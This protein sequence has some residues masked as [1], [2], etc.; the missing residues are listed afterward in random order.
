MPAIFEAA[1]ER[2]AV[3][4]RGDVLERLSDGYWEC[5]RWRAVVK[6]IGGGM[7][8]ALNAAA[9]MD[10]YTLSDRGT[11]LSFNNRRDLAIVLEGD[12]RLLNRYDVIEL[13]PKLHAQAKL[14]LAKQLADWLA[15]PP[16]QKAIGE[17]EMSGQKLFRPEADPKP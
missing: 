8:A 7:G 16:G 9:G 12:S 10:P 6:D 15:S 4:V 1:F 17:Y 13:N 2:S 5:A 14:D 3:R 11:W